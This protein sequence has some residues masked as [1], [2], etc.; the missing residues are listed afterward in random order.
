MKRSV[1]AEDVRDDRCSFGDPDQR[2]PYERRSDRVNDRFAPGL[3]SRLVPRIAEPR[4]VVVEDPITVERRRARHQI[5]H[6]AVATRQNGPI[7]A[8]AACAIRIAAHVVVRAVHREHETAGQ[9]D[10]ESGQSRTKRD[11]SCG[12][13][14]IA[15]NR[16]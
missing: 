14:R 6:V 10:C 13:S 3:G 12:A 5:E 8:I 16:D 9:A 15:A 2:S 7:V 4:E 11:Q 1:G